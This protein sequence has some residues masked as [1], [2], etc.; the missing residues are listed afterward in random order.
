MLRVIAEGRYAECWCAEFSYAECSYVECDYAE[1]CSLSVIM[2]N[3]VALSLV[4]LSVIMLNVALLNFTL[5]NVAIRLNVTPLWRMSL[6]RVSSLCRVSFGRMLRRRPDAFVNSCDGLGHKFKEFIFED[7][8]KKIFFHK[9][10]PLSF[11]QASL[12]RATKTAR[13]CSAISFQIW[14]FVWKLL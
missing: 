4:M 7:A 14:M 1:C 13:F 10:F 6:G 11:F 3:V 8:K 12:T 2:L 5:S 9:N